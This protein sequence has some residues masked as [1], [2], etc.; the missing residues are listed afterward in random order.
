MA[1]AKRKKKRYRLV[2]PERL[3]LAV[4]LLLFAVAGIYALV[5]ALRKEPEPEESVQA[6]ESE[7]PEPEYDSLKGTLTLDSLTA[8]L[9]G[10][11]LALMDLNRE[12]YEKDPELP[13]EKARMQVGYSYCLVIAPGHGGID[14]GNVKGSMPEKSI[15]LAVGLAVR[16]YIEAH[17]TDIKVVMSRTTDVLINYAGQYEVANLNDADFALSL[18]CNAYSGS[19]RAC[20]T[21]ALYYS[22]GA[23]DEIGAR[24]KEAAA[25]L[26][27]A[28]SAIL[29][30]D[31]RGAKFDRDTDIMKDYPMAAAL[32]ELGFLS[33]PSDDAAL[34][35][36]EIQK[37]IGAAIGQLMI[38]ILHSYPVRGESVPEEAQ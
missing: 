4:L 7:V 13:P 10:M 33:D 34:C 24:S 35:D 28:V 31:D 1:T 14:N 30:S 21:E 11:S 5:T 6:V 3:L 32:V 37:E 15:N 18:H 20:G 17:C 23:E 27:T 25:R 9:R 38:D 12:N 22:K 36:P 29:G 26:S 2:H 8:Q 16:D 19:G